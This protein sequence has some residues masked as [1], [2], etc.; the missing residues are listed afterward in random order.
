MKRAITIILLFVLLLGAFT[1]CGNST[2][3]TGAAITTNGEEVSAQELSYWINRMKLDLTS[4]MTGITENFWKNNT[5]Y[6]TNAGEYV[7]QQAI[8]EAENQI[9]LVQKSK[10]EGI[11]L[12]VEELATIETEWQS[13]RGQH[14]TQAAFNKMLKD[15]RL[16]EELFR[17]LYEDQ[18]YVT[19]YLE[20]AFSD[21]SKRAYFNDEFVR[22]KH[23]LVSTRDE[24]GNDLPE[25]GKA[26]AKTE[27]EA[28][29]KRV[30]RN[31]DFDKLVSEYSDDPGSEASPDGYAFGKY[32][33]M[34]DEFA[35]A[36]LALEVNG[37]SELVETMYGYHI[38][39]RFEA[40]ETLFDAE[41]V[42]LEMSQ[43]LLE[44]IRDGA[45]IQQ[46]QEVIDQL[47]V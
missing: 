34:I 18:M 23:I 15:N 27:A 28:L 38:I 8:I 41:A 22:V 20:K 17:K 30:K 4:E 40:S 33:N 1:G 24:E 44:N 25:E 7:K 36:S 13:L 2:T 43:Y 5:I 29:L 42:E 21:D 6:G 11:V 39:K 12:S 14:T 47:E 31:E 45:D 19:K 26:T 46:H 10:A 32:G 3:V 9:L 37:V 16:T 35:E